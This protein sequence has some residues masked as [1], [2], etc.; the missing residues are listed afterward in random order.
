MQIDLEHLWKNIRT[1]IRK[2]SHEINLWVVFDQGPSDQ[3]LRQNLV[4][5]GLP[6]RSL[7]EQPRNVQAS[8][9]NE[10]AAVMTL[11]IAMRKN[12]YINLH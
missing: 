7:K 2:Y 8:N 3:I 10:G 6:S 5:T 11:G 4:T 12:I 1:C 9:Q